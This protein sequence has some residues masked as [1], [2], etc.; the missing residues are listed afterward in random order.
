MKR[1][2]KIDKTFVLAILMILLIAVILVKDEY[3]EL[4]SIEEIE[5]EHRKVLDSLDNIIHVQDSLLYLD[6]LEL[7]KSRVRVRDIVNYKTVIRY[8][9]IEIFKRNDSIS[10]DSLFSI[11][12]DYF[13]G[14]ENGNRL[15]KTDAY[16]RRHGNGQ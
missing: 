13:E 8:E 12:S 16:R 15:S 1:K 6:S 5:F 4:P 14:I 7:N 10:H 9:T 11:Y 2:V 3:S